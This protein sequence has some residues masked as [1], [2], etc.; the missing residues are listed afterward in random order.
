ML[1]ITQK[2]QKKSISIK[3]FEINEKTDLN[4]KK[5]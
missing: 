3:L 1:P 2:Y 5:L 4:T